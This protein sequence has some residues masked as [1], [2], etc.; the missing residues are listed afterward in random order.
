MIKALAIAALLAVP[1]TARAQECIPP[2]QIGDTAVV[3]APFLIDSVVSACKA[4]LPAGSFINS[5]AA[6]F[7]E[8]LKTEGAPR[9]DSAIEILRMAAGKDVPQIEDQKALL[10][11]LGGL[12]QGM[13][14]KEI[15]PES[16]P[17]LDGVVAALAPLPTDNIALLGTSVATFIAI[18]EEN[19]AK[20]RAAEAAEAAEAG[21][22]AAADEPEPKS[23]K[24]TICRNG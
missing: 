10:T 13:I 20:K 24:P 18:E 23:N 14:A 11:V 12:A 15:K 5:G 19:A 2:Q 16:C 4:H 3:A 6:A 17:A 7:S 8:R 22:T 21:E 1:A 9:V